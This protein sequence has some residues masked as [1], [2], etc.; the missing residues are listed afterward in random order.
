M[1]TH[2]L[3]PL[4]LYDAEKEPRPDPEYAFWKAVY[5]E[6]LRNGLDPKDETDKAIALHREYVEARKVEHALIQEKRA[7]AQA[8]MFVKMGGG[9]KISAIKALREKTGLGLKEAKSAVEHYMAFGAWPEELKA[10]Y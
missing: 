9:K 10:L 6:A 5:F 8:E 3:L 7:F 2:Q 4:E 1:T